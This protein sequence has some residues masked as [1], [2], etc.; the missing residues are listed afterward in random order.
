MTRL[1]I[2]NSALTLIGDEPIVSDD[3]TG[4]QD[5]LGSQQRARTVN[6]IWQES[7]EE[8]L[9]AFPWGFVKTRAAL[10]ETTAPLFEWA[11]AFNL[12][13]DFLTF[14]ALNETYNCTPG[15][16]YEI[17]NGLFLTDASEANV[18]YIYLPGDSGVDAALTRANPLYRKALITLLAAKMATKRKEDGGNRGLQLMEVYSRNLSAAIV[19]A[20]AEAKQAQ[21]FP[22]AESMT[23]RARRGFFG[24]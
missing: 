13:D 16:D 4:A 14:V 23:L 24:A 9:A 7:F 18:E 22:A 1:E 10:V 2:I 12:P 17:E 15:E 5:G 8:W 11:T 21:N 19:K 3:L 20:S 6:L